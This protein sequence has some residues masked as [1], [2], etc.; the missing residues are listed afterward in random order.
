MW[1]PPISNSKDTCEGDREH[2]FFFPSKF[3]NEEG[4]VSVE[5]RLELPKTYKLN[6]FI[7]WETQ[8][9]VLFVLQQSKIPM[10]FTNLE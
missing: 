2:V 1:N 3:L 7:T 10:L 8:V 6:F 9:M 5:I 4:I